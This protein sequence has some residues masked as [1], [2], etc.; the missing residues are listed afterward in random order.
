MFYHAYNN[1]LLYGFPFDD[2]KPISC[3]GHDTWGR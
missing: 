1:Y 3:K 2:L